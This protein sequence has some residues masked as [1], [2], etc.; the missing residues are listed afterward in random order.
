MGQDINYLETTKG[1]YPYIYTLNVIEAIQ[2]KYG[3]IKQWSELVEREG[4]EPNIEALK[5]FFK[6]A[7]NEGIE[8]ENE[9]KKEEDKIAIIDEKKV[10]RIISEIG[11]KNAAKK[12]TEAVI[13]GSSKSTEDE[14][15]NSNEKN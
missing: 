4:E 14:P 7:I 13:I 11:F 12:L 10:G 6:E 9:D 3:S 5:F 15:T 8:I 2:K 1:K